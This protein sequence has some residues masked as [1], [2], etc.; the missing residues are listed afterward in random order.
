M[1]WKHIDDAPKDG[2]PILACRI[3]FDKRTDMAD[4]PRTVRFKE[5]HPNAPGKGA[6]RNSQGW[7]ENYI[8]HWTEVP[9]APTA[10]KREKP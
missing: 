3:G 6:W 4:H 2:T 7:K 5:F 1:N 9:P 8:T 10:D